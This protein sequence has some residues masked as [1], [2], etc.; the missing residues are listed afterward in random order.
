MLALETYF[1]N[2]FEHM[3]QTHISSI[4][5]NN[6]PSSIYN[7]QIIVSEKKSTHEYWLYTQTC[8]CVWH[9]DFEVL[10]SDC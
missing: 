7:L 9:Y 10:L 3:P 1:W 8:D 4:S 6:S 5:T 2:A